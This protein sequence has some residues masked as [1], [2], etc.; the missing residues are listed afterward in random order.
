MLSIEFSTQELT[1]DRQFLHVGID[2]LQELTSCV[3]SQSVQGLTA[4]I[5]NIRSGLTSSQLHYGLLWNPE[6]KSASNFLYFDYTQ[7][8]GF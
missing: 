5:D 6:L 2:D 8:M 7:A 3:N 1:T 4:K